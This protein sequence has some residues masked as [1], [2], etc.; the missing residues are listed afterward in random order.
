MRMRVLWSLS[1]ILLSGIAAPPGA[2][3]IFVQTTTEVAGLNSDGP[4][5]GADDFL[6]SGDGVVRSVIWDGFR[7]YNTSGA[8]ADNV[9]I[10]FYSDAAGSVGTLIGTFALGTDV[11]RGVDQLAIPGYDKFVYR[12]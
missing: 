9:T 10:R 5:F 11:T 7:H 6:L 8:P 3:P 2:V 12:D 1:L 4:T